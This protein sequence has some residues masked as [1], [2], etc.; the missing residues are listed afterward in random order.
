LSPSLM[1]ECRRRQRS[2]DWHLCL[3]EPLNF[4]VPF[5][6]DAFFFKCSC[7]NLITRAYTRHQPSD[8]RALTHS[9]RDESGLLLVLRALA[10]V[11]HMH[12]LILARC[13]LAARSAAP[14][15]SEGVQ[16]GNL[17][18]HANARSA[19]T[20]LSTGCAHKW[21]T[22]SAQQSAPALSANMTRISNY[23]APAA[24]THTSAPRVSELLDAPTGGS[25]EAK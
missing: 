19:A 5:L 24:H 25:R 21:R 4:W 8:S 15:L 1:R 2:I 7:V 16:I 20:S 17:A 9:V 18:V 10:G 12:Y 22:R 6:S 23:S 14:V 3:S 13:A 11:A